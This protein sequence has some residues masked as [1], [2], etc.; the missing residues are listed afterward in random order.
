[1]IKDY[2]SHEEFLELKRK[3]TEF[4]NNCKDSI[5]YHVGTGAGLYSELGSM[6]ECMVYCYINKIKFVLYADDANFSN[7]GWTDF[8][9]EFCD[10]SHNKL[11]HSYNYRYKSHFRWKGL[12]IPNLLFRRIIIPQILKWKEHVTFLTQDK[13]KEIVSRQLKET[14]FTWTD[15][16]IVDGT[17]P[18]DYAKLRRL[19]LRYNEETR[20]E[21]ERRIMEL[22]L[23]DHYVS[24]QIR[25]GDKA[26]EFQDVMDADFCLKKI[27]ES[28]FPVNNI[29]VFTDDYRNV[30]YIK[31]NRPQWN[32]YTLTRPE[33]R[34]YYNS[35]FNEQSWDYRKDNLLKV[36]A[37]VEICINSDLH[38]G[39]RQACINHIIK[40]ARNGNSYF[41]LDNG[42]CH[43]KKSLFKEFVRRIVLRKKYY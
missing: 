6:L 12:V 33:E 38:F 16:D 19:A 26:I 8:F 14:R 1:M 9:E 18:T 30:E 28:K 5:I 13:F 34:G 17:I 4:N 21:I 32:V 3:Y 39:N 2:L 24:V 36:F 20:N 42:S 7:N 41:E 10:M 23:P 15:F 31:K 37:I 29:F 40:S 22:N 27:E 25:G 43:V 35:S 11:N